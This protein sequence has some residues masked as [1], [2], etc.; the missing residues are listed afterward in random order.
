MYNINCFTILMFVLVNSKL[1]HNQILQFGTCAEVETMKFFNLEKFLGVWYEIER[2]PIWY[3]EHAQCAYKRFQACGRRIEIEY[4][5]VREGIQFILH[6]NSSYAPGDEAVFTLEKN[7]IDPLGIPLSVIATDYTNYA[8]VYG[9][10]NN[11]ELDIK[12]FSAWILSRYKILA[13][14]ILETAYRDINSIPYI[15]TAYL[16]QVQQNEE[17]CKCHWTAHVQAEDNKEVQRD[18]L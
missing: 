7:N 17:T 16:E 4:G 8:V 13:P 14:E 2:I 15:S 9:C 11:E 18:E 12:Y 1:C 3:E 5:F 10:R 6:V